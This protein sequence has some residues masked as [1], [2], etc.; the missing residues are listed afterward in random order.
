[1]G[2]VEFDR[3]ANHVILPWKQDRTWTSKESNQV[4]N[5]SGKN[6]PGT[7]LQKGAHA[8]QGHECGGWEKGKNRMSRTVLF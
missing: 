5:F 3:A 8:G 1:M 7:T 2:V 6:F 4:K